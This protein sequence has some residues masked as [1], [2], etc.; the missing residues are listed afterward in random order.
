MSEGSTIHFDRPPAGTPA[1]HLIRFPVWA[2]GAATLVGSP[3]GQPNDMMGMDMLPQRDSLCRR[4]IEPPIADYNSLYVIDRVS[5]QATLIGSLGVN[6]GNGTGDDFLMSLAFAPNGELYGANVFALF[7]IDP[8]TGLATKVVD[9][10]GERAI[11]VATVHATELL[12]P[13]GEL[14]RVEIGQRGS[15]ARSIRQGHIAVR[16]YE[17]D[18]IAPQTRSPP[19]E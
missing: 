4:P 13:Q 3:L 2:T 17:I 16:S 1:P 15:A 9:F 14:A 5:G 12:P 6:D 7:K 8:K 18:G 11:M 19:A 10:V